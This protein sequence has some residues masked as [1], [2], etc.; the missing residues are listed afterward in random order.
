MYAPYKQSAPNNSL[1]VNSVMSLP[2]PS[3]CRCFCLK[4][5]VAILRPKWKVVFRNL[6][7]CMGARTTSQGPHD[8]NWISGLISIEAQMHYCTIV[9][10]QCYLE[11]SVKD[12]GTQTL[13]SVHGHWDRVMCCDPGLNLKVSKM[14]HSLG[15]LDPNWAIC[16]ENGQNFSRSEQK[17]QFI[18]FK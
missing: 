5:R 9:D 7:A 17:F 1:T 13:D 11:A 16:L 4:Q 8:S 6:T 18:W 15:N 10:C 14:N 12:G 2:G 3:H